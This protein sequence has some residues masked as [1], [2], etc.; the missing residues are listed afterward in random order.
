M[1]EVERRQLITLKRPDLA[2]KVRWV[3]VEDGDGAGYD[4]LSFSPEGKERQ[5]EVKTTN[6]SAR[7]PFFLTRNERAV[8]EERVDS[9]QLYRVHLFAQGPRIFSV[10]PPLEEALDLRTETWRAAPR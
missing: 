2:K 10:R 6:G 7:T 1:L 3:A 4:V 5:I 9:W 8:A